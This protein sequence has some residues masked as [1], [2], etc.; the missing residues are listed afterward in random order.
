MQG[1]N[2]WKNPDIALEQLSA[3]NE[4]DIRTGIFQDRAHQDAVFFDSATGIGALLDGHGRQSEWNSR[5]Q[6]RNYCEESKKT[7][8]WMFQQI[9]NFFQTHDLT[10]KNIIKFRRSLLEED[11]YKKKFK[12][13][14]VSAVIIKI[15]EKTIHIFTHGDCFVYVSKNSKI[16]LLPRYG[17]EDERF[18]RF[19]VFGQYA[20]NVFK[21]MGRSSYDRLPLSRVYTKSEGGGLNISRSLGDQDYISNDKTKHSILFPEHALDVRTIDDPDWILITSDG[22]VNLLDTNKFKSLFLRD[23]PD[24]PNN[25]ASMRTSIR[26]QKLRCHDDDAS[27]LFVRN[28]QPSRSTPSQEDQQASI[29]PL[30]AAM[31]I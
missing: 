10:Q 9:N 18:T 31:M 7:N 28:K 5:V 26:V 12:Y 6:I 15:V 20:K 1:L 4:F 29:I 11:Y 2:Y 8:E 25:A 16:S 17:T 27:Y 23:E 30:M 13:Y 14:G 24:S 22:F 3:T 21:N 19:Q